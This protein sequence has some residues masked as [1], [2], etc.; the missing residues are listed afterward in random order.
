MPYCPNC[1]AELDS[2]SVSSC[3]NCRASFGPGS[4]WSPTPMPAERFRQL[5]REHL[6][7]ESCEDHHSA[8]KLSASHPPME[9]YSGGAEAIALAL[10][11]LFVLAVQAMFLAMGVADCWGGCKSPGPAI[12]LLATSAVTAAIV[13]KAASFARRASP[14]AAG[15]A[16]VLLI[17]VLSPAPLHYWARVSDY[18]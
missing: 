8:T 1:S 13:F 12:A 14:L 2:G 3:W 7:R 11:S 4:T 18:F 16:F 6:D 17:R 9:H 5:H 15:V 10:A